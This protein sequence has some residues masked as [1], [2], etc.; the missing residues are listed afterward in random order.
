MHGGQIAQIVTAFAIAVSLTYSAPAA[1]EPRVDE[2]SKLLGSSS[3]KTRLSAV[4]SLGRL[5]DKAAMKPL[6]TA[7]SDPNAQVRALAAAALGRIGHKAALP[8]LRTTATDDVDATVRERARESAIAVAKAN[9][10]PDPWPAQPTT[11]GSSKVQARKSGGSAGFGRQAH[12]VEARPNLFVTINSSADDSPGKAD[13]NTR[14]LHGEIIK[15]TLAASFKAEPQVT[16]LASE[17]Q[18]WGLDSRHLD[19]SVTKLDVAQ[20]GSFIEI[21]AQLRLA[22]SDDNGK[23]LS[24]LSGG[25]KVQVPAKT[26]NAKYLPN[27]RREALENAMRGMFAKLLTHLRDKSQS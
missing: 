14:K 16:T 4:V 6:V 24:F 13:K 25:A 8:A 3:E 23:M 10:L 12:A 22:I 7:L 18:R 15:T 26:Y 27:L 21:E 19:L 20:T 1:A 17:A 2:L 5:N 9:A 11:A